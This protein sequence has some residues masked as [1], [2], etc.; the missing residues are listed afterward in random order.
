MNKNAFN[1]FHFALRLSLD[2]IKFEN[3]KLVN[4]Y[5]PLV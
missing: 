2:L 5:A 4:D 1:L 3:V